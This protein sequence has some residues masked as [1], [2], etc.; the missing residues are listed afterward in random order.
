MSLVNYSDFIFGISLNYSLKRSFSSIAYVFCSKYVSTGVQTK[1][2]HGT[3]ED[4]CFVTTSA[5]K[6]STTK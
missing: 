6:D 4:L 3:H 5:V 2:I 1:T